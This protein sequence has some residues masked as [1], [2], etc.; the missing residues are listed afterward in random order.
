LGKGKSGTGKGSTGKGSTGKG[1]TGK[2]SSSTSSGATVTIDTLFASAESLEATGKFID[3]TL[4]QI[5]AW[6]R[7]TTEDLIPPEVLAGLTNAAAAM[8]KGAPKG[9]TPS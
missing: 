9:A 7:G 6:L 8:Q 1:S 4:D 3:S 2:G 5:I